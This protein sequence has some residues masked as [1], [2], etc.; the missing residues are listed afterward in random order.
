[1]CRLR[2]VADYICEEAKRVVEEDDA[3]ALIRPEP[4]RW[5][6]GWVLGDADEDA[7]LEPGGGTGMPGQHVARPVRWEHGAG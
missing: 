4:V 7:A 6:N 1:V 5:R 2:V 3:A